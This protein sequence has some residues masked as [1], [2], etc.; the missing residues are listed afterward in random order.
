MP[1]NAV[2]DQSEAGLVQEVMKLEP[3]PGDVVVFKTD[4]K[5]TDAASE[6]IGN[7]LLKLPVRVVGI[8]LG[9][10]ESIETVDEATLTKLGLTRMKLKPYHCPKCGPLAVVT[11]DGKCPLCA[12]P[13]T[14]IYMK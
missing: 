14:S 12:G 6:M 11:K 13:A 9:P 4:P 7:M 8:I 10:G 3:K 5:L 2:V 1:H